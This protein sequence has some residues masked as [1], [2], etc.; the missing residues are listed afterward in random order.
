M[1]APLA[2]VPLQFRSYMLV[3]EVMQ[4]IGRDMQWYYNHKNRLIATLN[5]PRPAIGARPARVSKEL[6]QAW[7]K[8]YLSGLEA[9]EIKSYMAKVKRRHLDPSNDDA[10]FDTSDDLD[11]ARNILRNRAKPK[12]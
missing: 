1:A 5:F 11:D 6:G 9:H 12:G 7:I 3:S 10:P 2:P 4:A 8:A